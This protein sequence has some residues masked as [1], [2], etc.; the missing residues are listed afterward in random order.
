MVATN[1]ELTTS[2]YVI[3]GIWI[4]LLCVCAIKQLL[5]QQYICSVYACLLCLPS[6]CPSIQK[7][8]NVALSHRTKRNN[9][10]LVQV[11]QSQDCFPNI[12]PHCL[13]RKVISL[14]QMSEH[15]PAAHIVCTQTQTQRARIDI[16]NEFKKNTHIKHNMPTDIQ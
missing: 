14:V 7:S 13:L 15:L 3:Y 11:L 4:M 5:V 6:A 10:H 8:I 16:F 9:T 1:P 2:K 12:N